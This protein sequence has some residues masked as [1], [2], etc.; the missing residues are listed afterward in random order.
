[1][2][3][4][5]TEESLPNI[6][7]P[8]RNASEGG[9]S[10]WRGSKH[11]QSSFFCLLLMVG[12]LSN[13]FPLYAGC[14]LPPI[15]RPGQT[16]TWAAAN[17]PFQ[18]CADLTIPRG[19][20]VIV[21]P[22]V[23][24]QFQDHT[25][26]VSG[27][28]NAQGQ[29]GSHIIISATSNF[30][31]AI[32]LQGGTVNMTFADVTGQVRGG[33][34]KM[35]I[36]DT[37]FIGPN[38]L[39]FTLDILRP[40]LPPVFTLTRCTFLNSQMQITDTYLKLRDCGF[41]NTVT[42]VLRGY[43]CLRGV[44]TVQGRPLS[45]LRE[46]FQAI[47]P[48][49]VD[50]VHASNVS[51]AGGLS[52]TGG[53]FFLGLSNALQGNLYPVDIEGGLLPKSAVPRSGN[54]K[55]M[56]WAHDGGSQGVMRWAN[57]GLP[58]LVTNLIN[59]GGPLTIDPGV[60]IKFDPTVTGL[61][62]LSIV[63]TRRVIAKGLPNQL[64][65]FDALNPAAPW[66]GLHFDTN[67]TEG[68]NLD[69]AVVNRARFGVT[70]TDNFLQIS[71]SVIQNNQ[72]GVNTN[73][74][75]ILTLSKTRV[76]SNVTGAQ[77]TPQGSLVLS[78]P[79]LLSNWFQGNGTAVQ[80]QAASTVPAELNYWGDPTGPRTPQ[81]PR[82]QGDLITGPIDF[83]PFLTAPPAIANNPPVVGM[84]PFGFSWYGITT[85]IRPPEFVAETGEKLLLSWNL[86]NSA[87]VARQRILLSPATANFD[88]FGVTPIVLANNL[89]PTTTSF[90]VTVPAIAFQPTNTNQFL[91]IIATDSSG[92]QG[93]DQTPLIV[94]S[95]RITGN[96]Q[97]TSN[98]SAQT[99][100][101]GHAAPAINW[102]GSANGGTTEGFI[103]LESD[104]GLISLF[105]GNATL[106]V[107]STDT[108]RLVVLSYSNSNDIKWF[109]S[110]SY[111]SIRPD[112]GLGLRPPQVR[113]T[114][115]T[116]GAVFSGGS[117]VPITW[118]AS[119]PEGL[120][121]F[122]IQVSTN[123]GKTFHLITTGLVGASRS[124]NWRLPAS[125]GIPDV[126]VRVIARDKWFQN[127]SDGANVVFSIVP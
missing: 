84:V 65:T 89:S 78:A 93:W 70:N 117:V 111:F 103:F 64:I 50:G 52:L 3:M 27:I 67:S 113:L 51:T 66:D 99:F 39:I 82:G 28:L 98:Y 36:S 87:T 49:F 53:S 91:R 85:I 63:S 35:T 12:V 59:G 38:G 76:F 69:Y 119:A 124:F 11:W 54:T 44:N 75:G 20:R 23:E 17:S 33:P 80:N 13:A 30:P 57:L 43:A 108:A 101:G 2:G 121:S 14:N 6:Q 71:N 109:F 31:P 118:T 10:A 102:T 68:S 116:P 74:F 21:E 19:G 88:L 22:G 123:G 126:R 24:L 5:P 41:T 86:S 16:V 58:Y 120:R 95:R 32:T 122:D 105:G 56:I 100:V 72:I 37:R 81:N 73:T 26:T 125:S 8:F 45:I 25:L 60:T 96:I 114:S 83:K 61:A 107:L 46:T 48:L 97:I 92:Q 112:P 18:I 55:N 127:S 115:P 42:Q 104:G 62:G 9:L 29:T 4:K 110:N 77:S 79:N 47:Q 90:E 1:M 15:P 34:G 94:P 106:P 7:A 40:S